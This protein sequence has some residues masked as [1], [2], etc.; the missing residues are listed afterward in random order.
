[1]S[2]LLNSY[3]GWWAFRAGTS[4]WHLVESE[5]TDRLVMRC[6][7]QMRLELHGVPLVF[8][9]EPVCSGEQHAQICVFCMTRKRA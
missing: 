5:I 6:G 8:G 4:R 7:R 2:D 3:I 9:Q 1:M